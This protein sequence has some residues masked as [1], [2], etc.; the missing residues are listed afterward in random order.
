MDLL[1]HLKKNASDTDFDKNVPLGVCKVQ[2]HSISSYTAVRLFLWQRD[3]N[4][5]QQC[6]KI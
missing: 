4:A 2:N 3:Q 6:W 5:L 1:F